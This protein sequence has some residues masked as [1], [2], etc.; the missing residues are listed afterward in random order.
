MRVQRTR[1]RFARQAHL[2]RNLWMDT[3]ANDIL[4]ER[5]ACIANLDGTVFQFIVAQRT[6]SNCDFR[7]LHILIYMG[8]SA[9]VDDAV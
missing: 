7:R 2:V 1:P 9:S 4:L 3:S 6:W 8:V 5:V